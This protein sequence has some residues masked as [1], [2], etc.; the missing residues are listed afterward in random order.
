MKLNLTKEQQQQIATAIMFLAL[1]SYLYYKYF[2]SQITLKIKANT[3]KIEELSERLTKLERRAAQRDRLRRE[4]AS[5]ESEWETLKLKLP[6]ETDLPSILETIT[7]LA[8]KSRI[9]IGSLSPQALRALELYEEIP[10]S[11]NLT[12]SYHDL[13]QFLTSLAGV[14]RIFHARNVGLNQATP[15]VEQPWA[16]INASLSL[17]TFKYKGGGG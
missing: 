13:A 16:T 2:Y 12:G 9:K 15:S 6:E 7:V 14:E 11:T 10:F 3:V 4:I 8:Q 1:G 17:I 5:A